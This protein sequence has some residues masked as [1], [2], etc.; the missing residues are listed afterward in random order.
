MEMNNSGL[1]AKPE[2]VNELIGKGCFVQGAG[3]LAPIILYAVAGV[4]GV[5]IGILV[6][7]VLLIGGGRMAYSWRCGHCKNPISSNQ[8]RI[9][10]VCRADL[11]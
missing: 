1:T 7:L 6:M 4:P 9:C 8:V 10:P 3:L 11:Q 5:S 2:K